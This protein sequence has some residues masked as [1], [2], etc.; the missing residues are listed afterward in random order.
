MKKSACIKYLFFFLL[1]ACQSSPFEAKEEK[2]KG[3][4]N[5]Y[6]KKSDLG[7]S[8]YMFTITGGCGSCMQVVADYIKANIANENRNYSVLQK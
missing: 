8:I 4:L 6:Q 5:Y 3:L 2:L 7:K 1:C